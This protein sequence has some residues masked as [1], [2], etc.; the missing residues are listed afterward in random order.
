MQTGGYAF[1]ARVRRRELPTRLAMAAFIGATAWVVKP[2]A[3]PMIW[4]AAV[5]LTQAID[6]AVCRSLTRDGAA[7]PKGAHKAACLASASLTTAV[8]S[9][10]A[11]FLW[12]QG[13]TLGQQFALVQVAGALL[14]VSLHMHHARGM[15]IAAVLPHGMYF[16]GLPLMGAVAQGSWTPLLV[17]IACLLYLAHLVAAVRQTSTTTQSLR[18]AGAEAREAEGRAQVANAA[19]SDFLATISHEIRTPMN[20]VLSAANLLRRTRLDAR[21]REHVD[22]LMDAGD[23]LMGLLNDVLDFSKIEAGKMELERADMSVRDRIAAVSRMWGPRAA[24]AGVRLKVQVADDVPETVRTDPLRFQQILFN[25]LSNAVKF[26]QDG[27]IRVRIDWRAEGS[28]LVVAV[29]DTGVGIPADRLGGIFNSFEQVEAGTTRRFG[30]TGLG[31]AICRRLA[32]L[33]GGGLEVESE[34]GVGSIFT[35]TLPVAV[36][37]EAEARPAPEPAPERPTLQGRIIL[38][39]EDH[40]VNR[41]ILA[42][43]LEPQGCRLVTVENGVEAVEALGAQRFDAILMDMQMPR[44]DGLEATRRIRASAGLNAETPVIALTANAMEM[45]RAAWTEV[46]VER[47]LTKPIDPELLVQTLA[48]AC[49]TRPGQRRAA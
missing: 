47:F 42:L 25:L 28:R 3:W 1:V 17:V 21:Q 23:V 29:E 35:L 20:A 26:T 7:E 15:L 19:K 4:F 43:L 39:A 10:I 36:V 49:L 31:L 46:G 14:H 34:E 30:G 41:R 27:E 45:H 40:D 33:M 37:V 18:K 48:D 24:A 2:S 22:M 32:E 9:G 11:A 13:G 12:F 38:A 5:L 8:Y 44:M 6:W 16:L